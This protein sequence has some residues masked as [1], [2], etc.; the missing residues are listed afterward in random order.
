MSIDYITWPTA[1]LKPQ[2]S[3]FDPRP[4]SRSGGRTLGGVSRSVRTDRGY[5]V[6]SYNNI[7]LR[8]PSRPAQRR[9]WNAIRTYLGGTTGLVAVP[10]CSTGV[11]SA[12][13]FKDFSAGRV[14][15][16]DGTPFDDGTLYSQGLVDIEMASFAPLGATV[17]TLRLIH[18]PTASGVRF[19]YQHAMYDTGRILSQPSA[20]TY[21]VEI[22]PAIRMPIPAGSKLE[23]DE[24][25]V[26]CHLATD[27]EMDIDI[28]ISPMSTA[29]VSFVEAVDVWND[30]ALGVLTP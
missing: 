13:G 18:A 2:S 3:P 14:P 22:F 23:A 5:W 26:L 9:T 12:A 1:I 10:V 7:L 30:I 19:S 20:D 25:T 6:G 4:F 16:D 24:P 15:H 8:K 28:G 27:N 11:W 17:V 21:Q 29:S